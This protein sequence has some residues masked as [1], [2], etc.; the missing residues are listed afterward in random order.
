MKKGEI[1]YGDVHFHDGRVSVHLRNSQ[2]RVQYS[3]N[4]VIYYSGE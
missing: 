1:T 3:I 2:N 4:P